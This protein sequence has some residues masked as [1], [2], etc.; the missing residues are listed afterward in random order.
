MYIEKVYIYLHE[1]VFM[2]CIC[3]LTSVC[4][5]F[6]YQLSSCSSLGISDFYRPKALQLSF[7]E[8]IPLYPSASLS[9]LSLRLSLFLTHSQNFLK[10]VFLTN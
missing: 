8:Q 6:Y 1:Y 4:Q 9:P 5:P 2:F 10:S 3:C 7:L